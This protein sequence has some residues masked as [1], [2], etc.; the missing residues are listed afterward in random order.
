MLI[1][2]SNVTDGE[3]FFGVHGGGGVL[4]GGGWHGCGGCG[5]GGGGGGEVGSN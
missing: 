1:F 5:G 4:F 2:I 3:T